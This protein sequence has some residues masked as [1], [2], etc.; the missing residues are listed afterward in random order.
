LSMEN[1]K[2]CHFQAL[3]VAVV[4]RELDPKQ[5]IVP[6]SLVL[7][8]IGSHHVFQDLVDSLYLAIHIWVIA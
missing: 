1:L 7:H 3:L 6:T 5:I 4:V 2:W 8:D